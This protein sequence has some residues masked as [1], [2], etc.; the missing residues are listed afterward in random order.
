MVSFYDRS[1][2][3][4]PV[5]EEILKIDSIEHLVIKNIFYYFFLL[6]TIGFLNILHSSSTFGL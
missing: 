4:I 6:F 2:R 3:S 1:S 5:E